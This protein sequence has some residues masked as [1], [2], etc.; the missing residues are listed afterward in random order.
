MNKEGGLRPSIFYLNDGRNSLEPESNNK[1]I[2]GPEDV[3]VNQSN[4]I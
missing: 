1:L 4:I 2:Q 3:S